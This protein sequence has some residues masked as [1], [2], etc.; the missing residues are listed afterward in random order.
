[1]A[2]IRKPA[3]TLLLALFAGELLSAPLIYDSGG[4]RVFIVTL[5]GRLALAALGLAWI[6]AAAMRRAPTL[7]A[8]TGGERPRSAPDRILPFAAA[9]AAVF[10]LGLALVPA[11]ALNSAMRRDAVPKS[12][13][14]KGSALEVVTRLGRESMQLTFGEPA[15]PLGDEALGITPGRLELDPVARQAWWLEPLAPQPRGTTLVYATQLADDG[16]GMVVPAFA[17]APLPEAQ[18]GLVSLCTVEDT[19]SPV[20]LGTMELRRIVHVEQ[21]HPLR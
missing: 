12:G 2:S 6:V 21:R 17:P 5:V 8:S 14:C 4:Q 15:L 13:V 20:R 7:Q 3:C 18:R 10:L 19:A 11:T 1:V 16:Q 9:G